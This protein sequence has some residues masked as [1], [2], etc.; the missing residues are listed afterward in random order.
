MSEYRKPVPVVD[1]VSRP[2][3]RGTKRREILLQKCR[4]CENLI[5]YPRPLCTKCFGSNFEWTRCSGYGTVYNYTVTYQ[6]VISG[7]DEDLP[8]VFAI[9]E[10]EEGVR[11]SSN[12]VGCSPEDVKI[13]MPVEVAFEEISEEVALPKFRP[14]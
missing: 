13:G 12:I 14:R 4:D 2:F 6:S 9:V 8:Y 10:L 11:V 7:F 3:W 5:Y 1:E